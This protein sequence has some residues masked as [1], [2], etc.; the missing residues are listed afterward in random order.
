MPLQRHPSDQQPTVALRTPRA[1]PPVGQDVRNTTPG[2][3]TELNASIPVSIDSE[4]PASASRPVRADMACVSPAAPTVRGATVEPLM[5]PARSATPTQRCQVC[6][7]RMTC[8]IGQLPVLHQERLDPLIREMAFRKGESLQTEGADPG[9]VR[10]VKLGTVMLHR[11]GPDGISRPV[12]LAGRGHLFGLWCLYGQ[13]TQ[14]SGQ[15]LTTG[16]V[17]ELPVPALRAVL[18]EEPELKGLLHQQMVETFNRLADWSQLMRLR[19]LPRQLVSALLLMAREQGTRTVHL[20]SQSAL[21]ALLCTSRESVARTLSLL[22][23]QGYL[24]RADRWH[25]ELTGTA[26]QIFR[27][28]TSD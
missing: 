26:R 24:H 15:A 9:V 16:R 10:T 11:T 4:R 22:E 23:D 6:A 13:S 25:G 18:E 19:G 14:V 7:A 17:C 1:T 2:G 8:L 28:D 20:P 21:A 27:N 5:P 3:P 12:A